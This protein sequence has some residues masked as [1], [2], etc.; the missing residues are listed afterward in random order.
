MSETDIAVRLDPFLLAEAR[1]AADAAG[2]AIDELVSVAVAEKVAALR[3]HAFF[4]E[5]RAR[6]NPARALEILRSMRG[7]EPPR[8]GDELPPDFAR[9]L[10][11]GA[12]ALGGMTFDAFDHDADA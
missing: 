4:A 2:I 9:E 12:E 8:P 6:A 10:R 3:T 11:T 7:G 1:H 5:R